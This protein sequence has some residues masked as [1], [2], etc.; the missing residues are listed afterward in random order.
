[1]TFSPPVLL[2]FHIAQIVLVLA[3]A[4][5]GCFAHRDA[6][7]RIDVFSTKVESFEREIAAN[8]RVGNITNVNTITQFEG[9]RQELLDRLRD[10][11]PERVT[12]REIATIRGVSTR[13]VTMSITEDANGEFFYRDSI[14]RF[15]HAKKIGARWMIENPYLDPLK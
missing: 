1:M 12:T 7:H 2:G 6:C 8:Q 10:E 9:Q 13:Y 15:W 3:L 11:K 4:V 5:G 14:G